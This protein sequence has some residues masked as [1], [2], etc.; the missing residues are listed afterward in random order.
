MAQPQTRRERRRR[1]KHGGGG[2]EGQGGWGLGGSAGKGGGGCGLGRFARRGK[3]LVFGGE[4][5][6][7]GAAVVPSCNS[8]DRTRTRAEVRMAS[9]VP[10]WANVELSNQLSG[11]R[12]AGESPTVEFKERFPDQGH[13]LAQ[14]LAA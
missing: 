12:E 3:G 2:G 4:A 1:R 13:R 7:M 6:R 11:V 14:E 9:N 10:K 8:P 5:R